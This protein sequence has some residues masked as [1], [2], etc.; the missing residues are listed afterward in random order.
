MSQVLADYL[1]SYDIL[2]LIGKDTTLQRVAVGQDG[3]EYAGKCPWCGGVDRFRVWPQHHA[4]RGRFWCRQCRRSGD[5]VAYLEADGLSF[6]DALREI[7]FAALDQLAGEPKRR[8][9]RTKTPPPVPTME[10]PGE[11]WQERARDFVRYA[12]NLLWSEHGRAALA[13]LH[14]RGLADETIRRFG[15]GFNPGDLYDE[16]D[17]WGL[18]A[19][20]KVYLSRG[21]VIPCEIDGALWYVQVRRP[22]VKDGQPD[23]LARLLGG[24]LPSWLPDKKYWSVKGGQGKALFG[25]GL[26]AGGDLPLLFCEGEFDAMIAWQTVGG[27]SG[28]AG[29]T[30]LADE[31]RQAL[32]DVCTLGGNRK[33]SGGLPEPWRARVAGY[34]LVLVAFDED[35]PGREG[36]LDLLEH[37]ARARYARIVEGND[38]T[39]FYLAGGDLRAWVLFFSS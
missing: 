16:L 9:R 12:Q 21:V 7:G 19:G 18:E 4:G 36:A 27:G 28:L 6:E 39:D 20:K 1:A 34:E 13:Y 29:R 2:A 31:T 11:K 24:A 10:P 23:V 8:K 22:Y 35:G 37:D 32:A 38:L 14:G 26:F 30:R 25:A 5:A 33:A 17:K 15:L 3:P